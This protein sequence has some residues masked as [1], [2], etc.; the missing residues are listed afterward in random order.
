M[1]H[2]TIFPTSLET[3]PHG[4][5]YDKTLQQLFFMSIHFVSALKKAEMRV[6]PYQI[7]QHMHLMLGIKSEVMVSEINV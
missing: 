5:D 2:M 1:I 7:R 6:S 4:I 3:L